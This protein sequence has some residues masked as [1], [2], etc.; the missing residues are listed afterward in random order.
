MGRFHDLFLRNMDEVL[1]E[2]FLLLDPTSL[3]S[4]RQVKASDSSSGQM[5]LTPI[6]KLSFGKNAGVRPMEPIHNRSPVEKQGWSETTS[7]K[8]GGSVERRKTIH[9]QQG[10]L[11]QH[12]HPG[13]LRF[14]TPGI[15]QV[16]SEK[17]L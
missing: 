9:Q 1:Q 10:L 5:N 8:V 6:S 17:Q 16:D 13:G 12:G 4:A 2:I 15:L 11:G 7:S 3:H 14:Q